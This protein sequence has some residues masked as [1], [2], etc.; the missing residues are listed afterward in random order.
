MAPDT[1]LE[2][3]EVTRL[4]GGLAALKDVSFQAVRRAGRAQG[5]LLHG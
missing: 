5:R 1:I 2:I 3:K 4:F